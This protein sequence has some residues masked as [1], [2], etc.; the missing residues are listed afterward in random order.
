MDIF[1]ER[2]S[3]RKFRQEKISPELLDYIA[4]CGR[5]APSGANL[6]PLQFCI[7]TEKVKEIFPHTK[8]AGYL[9]EWSPTENEAPVA[10]IAIIGDKSIK[11]NGDFELDAGIAGTAMT[12][13]AESKG[14]SSCWLASIDRPKISEILGLFENQKLLY[15][16]GFGYK[17]QESNYCDM[18]DGIK[19]TMDENGNI[20]VPKRTFKSV[21][22]YK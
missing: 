2:R 8:W 13:A 17:D 20:T 1:K 10:Y 21:V 9:P 14:I 4:D 15:L 7:I 19:Y 18:S 3:I 22:S 11:E 6:Q 5:L 16:I 12:Y